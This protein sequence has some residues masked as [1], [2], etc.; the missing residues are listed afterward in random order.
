MPPSQGAIDHRESP[1]VAARDCCRSA[2]REII[3]VAP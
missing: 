2:K 1:F 3:S